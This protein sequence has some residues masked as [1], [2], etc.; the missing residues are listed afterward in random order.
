MSIKISSAIINNSYNK[1]INS[2][3]FISKAVISANNSS[4]SSTEV[5]PNIKIKTKNVVP[6]ALSTYVSDIKDNSKD[7]MKTITDLYKNK[8]EG[9]EK[10]MYR[11]MKK[12]A[13]CYNDIIDTNKEYS[14]DSGVKKLTKKLKSL[15][16]DNKE[17]LEN[18]GITLK[19]NGKL[20]VNETKLLSAAENG[21]LDEFLSSNK[22]SL[23]KKSFIDEV[24]KISRKIYRDQTTFLSDKAKEILQ[25]P[26]VTYEEAV[27]SGG[28]DNT[29]SS[30]GSTNT[31]D[32]SND[33]TLG[34][35][36]DVNA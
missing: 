16:E 26:I 35:N 7:M 10:E 2:V 28:T 22:D 34:M 14:T 11:S 1:S 30:E 3:R 18:M 25:N 8:S 15:V 13:E 5:K 27:E 21:E 24:R 6:E 9:N 36:I 31:E 17:E 4:E 12:F 23:T 29:G 20:T 32:N 19:S 33:N